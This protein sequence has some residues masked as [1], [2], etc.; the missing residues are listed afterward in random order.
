MKL[1]GR[2][3]A[4]ASDI[5]KS[6]VLLPFDK[7]Q[8]PLTGLQVPEYQLLPATFDAR[9]GKRKGPISVGMF[10]SLDANHIFS[11]YR[12]A[13][14]GSFS[15]EIFLG[16]GGGISFHFR[17]NNNWALEIGGAYASID[18]LPD[19]VVD[20]KSGSFFQGG[21]YGKGISSAE[22]EVLKVPVN[23]QYSLSNTHKWNIYAVTG[24]TANIAMNKLYDFQRLS[25]GPAVS[26][27]SRLRWSA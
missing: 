16:Y 8:H 11:A 12:Q 18:Y 4:L 15:D 10:A 21:Y 26:E 23:L 2:L 27:T 3:S 17:L 20:V 22:L 5:T 7:L 13:Q 19:F 24:A 14:N 9:A 6:V 1:Y 25:P